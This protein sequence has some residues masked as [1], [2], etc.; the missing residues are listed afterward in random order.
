V[1]ACAAQTLDPQRIADGSTMRRWLEWAKPLLG[2]GIRV[3][4]ATRNQRA[5]TILAWD[6]QQALLKLNPEARAG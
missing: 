3:A 2:T 5:P 4:A 6:F 1:E